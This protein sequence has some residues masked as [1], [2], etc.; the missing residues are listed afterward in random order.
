KYGIDYQPLSPPRAAPLAPAS[1]PEQLPPA[2]PQKPPQVR[3]VEDL[4][5]RTQ[6]DPRAPDVLG[7]P[8]NRMPKGS[9]VDIAGKCQSWM[10]SGRGAEDADNIWC[11]VSYGEHRGWAN[12]YYLAASDGRPPGLRDVSYR[13]RLLACGYA[14]ANAGHDTRALQAWLGHRNNVSLLHASFPP[15][16]RGPGHGGPVGEAPR[17]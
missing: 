4:H 3:V 2:S 1:R 9:Q 7:P 11:Q 13:A 6:P 12:A 17:R 16:Q 15:S 5:L 14:L 8:N 10:G